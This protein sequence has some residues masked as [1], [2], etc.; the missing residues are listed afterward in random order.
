[1]NAAQ[2]HYSDTLITEA[3]K[4]AKTIALVGASPKP[5]R[6]SYRVMQFLLD[7]GHRVIPVNPGLEGKQ[8]LGQT[9]YASLSQIKERVHMVDIFRNSE[10]AGAVTDEALTLS[11]L[12]LT[13]WMQ[14]DVINEEAANRATEKGLTPIMN[15]CP[16]I[17]Y[18]R[19]GL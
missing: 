17:E 3:L 1:M 14:L 16:K 15:R 11:P 12:P 6:P 5:E 18:E 4:T 2:D 7:K 9:V 10:A 13:I 8:I 19:L